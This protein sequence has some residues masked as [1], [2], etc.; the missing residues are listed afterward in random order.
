MVAG[1]AAHQS[2]GL[3]VFEATFWPGREAS[4]KEDGLPN[5]SQ[6]RSFRFWILAPS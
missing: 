4:E 1:V 5:G 2:A 6:W 3:T